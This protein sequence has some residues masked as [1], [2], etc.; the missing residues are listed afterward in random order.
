MKWFVIVSRL[1]I[2][3]I[4]VVFGLNAFFNFISMEKAMPALAES[5]VSAL[6]ASRYLHVIKVLEILGGS[7][8]LSNQFVP[9]GLTILMPII[10]NIVLFEVFL[11]QEPGFGL[12]MLFL[13][14]GLVFAYRAN[15]A[16]VFERKPK[17]DQ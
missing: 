15:F 17:L 10:V 9:L 8:L 16:S 12:L 6:V 1:L 3:M 14:T 5:Y 13:A 4:F 2:G 7:L 11:L